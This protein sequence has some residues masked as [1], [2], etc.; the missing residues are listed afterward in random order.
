MPKK[1]IKIKSKMYKRSFIHSTKDA[2]GKLKKASPT[3]LKNLKSISAHYKELTLKELN[4]KQHTYNQCFDIVRDTYIYILKKEYNENGNFRMRGFINS[5]TNSKYFIALTNYFLHWK[6]SAQGKHRFTDFQKITREYFGIAFINATNSFYFQ[7][8]KPLPNQILTDRSLMEWEGYWEKYDEQHGYNIKE[9]NFFRGNRESTKKEKA[10]NK[11][12]GFKNSI[13]CHNHWVHKIDKAKKKMKFAKL[14]V[15]IQAWEKDWDKDDLIKKRK[16][17]I[18]NSKEK[19][20]FNNLMR[21]QVKTSYNKIKDLKKVV[22][23]FPYLLPETIKNY[24]NI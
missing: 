19:N 10:C 14:M 24:I 20:S 15:E 4:V 6:I 5:N 3:K 2:K 1:R 21:I 13:E 11:E 22:E 9:N 18:K 12:F 8:N 23:K 16:L 7:K 17:K